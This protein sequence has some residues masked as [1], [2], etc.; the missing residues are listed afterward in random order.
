VLT[1]TGQPPEL[2]DSQFHH[3]GHQQSVADRATTAIATSRDGVSLYYRRLCNHPYFDG[4]RIDVEDKSVKGFRRTATPSAFSTTD[5]RHAAS[6]VY[7]R[8]R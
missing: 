6:H 2:E 3:T 1:R 4:I 8:G 7:R 5:G